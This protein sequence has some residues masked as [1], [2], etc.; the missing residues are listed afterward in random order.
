[1]YSVCPQEDIYPPP[2]SSMRTTFP[3]M[4]CIIYLLYTAVSICL[5]NCQEPT[6]QLYRQGKGILIDDDGECLTVYASLRIYLFWSVPFN[7]LVYSNL[8]LSLLCYDQVLS[9]SSL[10]TD[11]S[12]PTVSLSRLSKIP[13]S[14]GNSWFI[15]ELL[16]FGIPLPGQRVGT[17]L[18][19]LDL[20]W[21]TAARFSSLEE[22]FTLKWSQ[23]LEKYN[24][25]Y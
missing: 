25:A 22:E 6:I 18:L 3:C 13:P 8:S 1:M 12:C 16:L 4:Y 14:A 5:Y 2:S 7:G 24:W 19:V 10:L 11:W 9:L 15:G 20:T 21:R 23:A 17:E